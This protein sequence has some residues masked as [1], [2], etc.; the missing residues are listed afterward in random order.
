MT[1]TSRD[2]SAASD[3]RRPVGGLRALVARDWWWDLLPAL[4]L[5][6]IG[7]G[8]TGPAGHNQLD[9]ARTPDALGYGL[10]VVAALSLLLRRR[11][12]VAVLV[13]CGLTIA[14]YL[15]LDYPFG[16]VQLVGPAAAWSV[17][18]QLPWRQVAVW[19]GGLVAVVP[20]AAAPRFVDET[21]VGW[22]G[23]LGWALTWTAVVAASAAIGAAVTSRQRSEEGVRLEQA[24]R[25]VSEERLAM[26]QDVHD[27][28]GHGLAVI[29]MQAGV[30]MHVFDR[31]PDRARELLAT[32]RATSREALDG[33][34][35]D[36][37]RLRSGDTSAA[38]RPAP[39]LADLPVLLERMRSGGLDVRTELTGLDG[40][41]PSAVDGAAY[42]IVQESLTN[43]LR[44]AGATPVTVRVHR[45][46]DALVLEIRD[47][48]RGAPAAAGPASSGLG[49]PGM[50]QRAAAVG[51][52]LQAGPAPGRGFLVRAVLPLPPGGPA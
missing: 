38:R 27:G 45:E 51:G 19:V 24:R 15:F 34:R 3:A 48:G 2:A 17:G 37:D 6:V 16:P 39:G 32:I 49:I 52:T 14:G 23:F 30:A 41:L 8:G 22:L 11:Q 26:A 20:I 25:A 4:P 29:A 42:R 13:I 46:R 7:L 21:T 43:V 35:A 28:V 40:E 31:D 9:S 5:L 18:R 12:P 33:L 10:V 50:R 44:H 36:L 47:R 1:T